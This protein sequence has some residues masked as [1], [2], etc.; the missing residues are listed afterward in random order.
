MFRK[1]NKKQTITTPPSPPPKKPHNKNNR[2]TTPNQ[3]FTFLL[4]FPFLSGRGKCSSR[5]SPKVFK[6]F[7]LCS[8]NS[9]IWFFSS[10]NS[11]VA[12]IIVKTYQQNIKFNKIIFFSQLK[13]GTYF[14]LLKNR[15]LIIWSIL[16]SKQYVFKYLF[17]HI[18][19]LKYKFFNMKNLTLQ[20]YLFSE[21]VRTS[22]FIFSSISLKAFSI[23]TCSSCHCCSLWNMKNKTQYNWQIQCSFPWTTILKS[24]LLSRS[25]FHLY[26]SRSSFSFSFFD[27]TADRTISRSFFTFCNY[28][29]VKRYL[30]SI[31]SEASTIC[32]M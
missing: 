4:A 2:K 19:F 25:S 6:S 30:Q 22:F 27:W 10:W 23:C 11:L 7:F 16:Q 14:L 24:Q 9:N 3:Q 21:S 13:E 31:S 1:T 15:H 8:F 29:K 18:L 26:L 32:S 28:K 5:N 20:Q 12:N 17:G